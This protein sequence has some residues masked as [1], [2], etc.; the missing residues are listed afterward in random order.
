MS[1]KYN[2]NI[3]YVTILVTSNPYTIAFDH[4]TMSHLSVVITEDLVLLSVDKIVVTLTN[5]PEKRKRQSDRWLGDQM[6]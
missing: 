1:D 6:A 5:S 2:K 4:V 3:K